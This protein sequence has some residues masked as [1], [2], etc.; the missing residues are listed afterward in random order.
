MLQVIEGNGEWR[1]LLCPLRRLRYTQA[2]VVCWRWGCLLL[3]RV[4]LLLGT[5][6]SVNLDCTVFINPLVF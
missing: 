5:N 6:A 1:G 3:F 2:L 4:L